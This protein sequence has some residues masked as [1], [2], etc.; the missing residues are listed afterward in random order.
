MADVPD[1]LVLKVARDREG[2]RDVLVRRIAVGA[3]ASFLAL[4]L[5][6]LFGQ[7]P[8]TTTAE[9][10]AARLE[11]YAPERVRGG[12]YYEARFRIDA[13]RE[14]EEA[15]LVLDSGWAEGIT[16]NTVE[17]S[18]LGEASRDGSLAFELGRIPAGQ[19]HLFFL[20]LQVNPTNVG[21]R[22]QNVRLYDG[23]ELLSTIDR[24]ITIFP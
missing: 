23:D 21:H 7:R 8:S 1:Q 10:D 14:L 20:H 22:P 19:K 6:N 5:L 3:I 24:T 2:K 4:G 17:P 13:L 18:P 12:L 15:T 11:V 9:S 16:I